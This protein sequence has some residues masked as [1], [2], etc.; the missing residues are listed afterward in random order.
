MTTAPARAGRQAG[1]QR[2]GSRQ[3]AYDEGLE[4]SYRFFDLLTLPERVVPSTGFLPPGR[5]MLSPAASRTSRS[6]RYPPPPR[7]GRRPLRRPPGRRRPA[8]R[9]GRRL[10]M[11]ARSSAIRRNA[12]LLCRRRGVTL[13]PS[14]S[15]LPVFQPLPVA[16]AN[17]QAGTGELRERRNDPDR[18][19]KDD[20]R[21]LGIHRPVPQRDVPYLPTDPHIVNA[22]LELAEL[23]PDD[24]LYDLGCGDGRIVIE[25]A[26]RGAGGGGRHRPHAHPRVSR[27]LAQDR[28]RR[29]GAVRPRELLRHRPARRYRRHALPPPRHQHQA[30]PQAP[31]GTAARARGSSPTT[32]RS[33]TGSPTR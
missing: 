20:P 5:S 9:R 31:L 12:A 33:A 27:K 17:K 23:K 1:R 28:R 24:V 2:P 6:P 4:Y 7:P 22:L 10:G 14:W 11:T 21:L 32:S 8:R 30:P 13:R 15:D 3:A 18:G 16:R 19:P 29:R 25:A 26:K